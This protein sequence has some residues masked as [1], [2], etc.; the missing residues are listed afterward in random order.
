LAKSS[1]RVLVVDDFE[2][3]RRSICSALQDK[4]ELRTIVEASDGQDAIERAQALQ[5]DLILMDIG[6]PK[7][8]GIEAARRIHFHD[9]QF[10]ANV[11]YLI[12]HNNEITSRLFLAD[13][14]QTVTF[15]GNDLNPASK[16]RGFPSPSDSA[17][18][19]FSLAHTY[20]FGN[21]W[22]NEAR[23][24]Y[25]RT[26]TSTEATTPFKWSDVGVAEGEMS[27]K[28]C[29]RVSTNDS[30]NHTT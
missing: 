10:S 15:P 18:T 8:D 25:V 6:L 28:R 4:L 21:A 17:F 5:P 7:L 27:H 2:P 29:L 19:V 26:I 20:T 11:D 13:D 23:I 24:G 3:F 1:I 22:L 12:R 30:P 14:D 16:I 9:D